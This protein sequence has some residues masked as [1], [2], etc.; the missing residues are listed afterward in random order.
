MKTRVILIAILVSSVL[1]GLTAFG[2]LPMIER[3]GVRSGRV[4]VAF[5]AELKA[6]A[7]S[8][9]VASETFGEVVVNGQAAIR[10]RTAAG[11][12]TPFD[13]ASV[14]AGRINSLESGFDAC[15][16]AVSVVRGQTAVVADDALIVTV[17]NREA[18]ANGKKVSDLAGEWAAGLKTAA[19][20]AAPA[21]PAS[22]AST[23]AP[24]AQP[25][26]TP[27]ATPPAAEESPAEEQ[28][29][30]GVPIISVGS[31][32]RVGLALVAGP[33]SQVAKVNAVAQL[34]ADFHKQARIRAL[35]PIDTES[36]KELHRVPM[37]S[38]IGVADIK[39]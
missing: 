5:A 3:W 17:D 35:V 21:E 6:E 31:G 10:I 4:E 26:P 28:V 32:L 13:R 8:V 38:V 12:L 2:L 27:P 37:T 20:C 23:P 33:S 14:V 36:V 30:K 25:T 22:S 24:E 15:H 11:G 34:E 19:G 39:L 18:A 9:T 1:G 16:F 7:R 29:Q